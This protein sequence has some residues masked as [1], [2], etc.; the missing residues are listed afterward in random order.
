VRFIAYHVSESQ[1]RELSGVGHFAPVLDPEP[2]ANDLVT[3]FEPARQP[4]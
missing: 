1:V 4:A 3:F 2:I